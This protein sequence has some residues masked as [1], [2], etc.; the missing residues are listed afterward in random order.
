MI[1]FPGGA[2]GKEPACQH[3]RRK[4]CDSPPGSGRSPGGGHSS[5]LQYSCLKNPMDTGAW[6]ATAHRFTK[7]QTWLKRLCTHT[8]LC[9]QIYTNLLTYYCVDWHLGILQFLAIRNKAAM[10]IVVNIFTFFFC[11]HLVARLPGHR[12]SKCVLTV[13]NC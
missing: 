1:I 13:E 6:Q 4:R 12:V 11:T 10:T 9:I 8:F 2:S 3:R 7:S 5:P